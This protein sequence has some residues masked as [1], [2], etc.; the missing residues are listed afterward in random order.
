M[1][2][3]LDIKLYSDDSSGATFECSVTGKI[4]Q[5]TLASSEGYGEMIL[6]DTDR[7]REVM[8]FQSNYKTKRSTLIAKCLEYFENNEDHHTGIVMRKIK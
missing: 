2:L 6:L 5:L 7:A 3:N 1:G 4:Y 8:R